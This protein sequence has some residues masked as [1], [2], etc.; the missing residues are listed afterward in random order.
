MFTIS[1]VVWNIRLY[2]DYFKERSYNYNKAINYIA[3]NCRNATMR[4]E[5]DT[6][7]ECERRIKITEENPSLYAL[8]DVAEHWL[9]CG[10]MGC[11]R[12]I[13]SMS[14]V[15]FYI[16]FGLGLIALILILLW[17]FYIRFATQQ[18]MSYVDFS[19]FNRNQGVLPSYQQKKVN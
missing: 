17:G 19:T 3:V 11:E 14:G 7:V 9:P 5:L 10:K 12:L 6:D 2:N 1:I 8:A 15:I 4:H 18:N 13:V 16:I